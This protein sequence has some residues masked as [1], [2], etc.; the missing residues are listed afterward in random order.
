M[1]TGV[2]LKTF[3]GLPSVFQLQNTSQPCAFSELD[4]VI[5]WRGWRTSPGVSGYPG[6]MNGNSAVER[7]TFLDD[8]VPGRGPDA[9]HLTLRREPAAREIVGEAPTCDWCS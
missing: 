6:P 4:V 1:P 8:P 9:C 5:L 7:N 3:G 2:R